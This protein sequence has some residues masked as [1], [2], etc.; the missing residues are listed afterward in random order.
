LSFQVNN[1]NIF[2]KLTIL[3]GIA[4][5]DL[6]VLHFILGVNFIFTTVEL[7]EL[8]LAGVTS[9]VS[10]FVNFIISFKEIEKLKKEIENLK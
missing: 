10:T 1:I 4:I 6:I 5:T 7:F 9:L 8:I 2:I 3:Q